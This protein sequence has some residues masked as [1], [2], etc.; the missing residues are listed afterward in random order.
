MRRQCT[1]YKKDGTRCSRVSET[2]TCRQHR[3]SNNLPKAG[4]VEPGLPELILT[5]RMRA[6]LDNFKEL[7][8]AIDALIR[9]KILNNY[10]KVDGYIV[11]RGLGGKHDP[12]RLIIQNFAIKDIIGETS[13]DIAIRTIDAIVAATKVE[14]GAGSLAEKKSEKSSEFYDSDNIDSS[15]SESSSCELIKTN[16]K[17]KIPIIEAVMEAKVRKDPA[18]NKTTIF[19]VTDMQNLLYN[20][21]VM[22]PG[23]RNENLTDHLDWK[24]LNINHRDYFTNVL[25]ND[26]IED[27]KSGGSP[28]DCLDLLNI[29][30]DITLTKIND[31]KIKTPKYCYGR[32][33]KQEANK[34][35]NMLQEILDEILDKDDDDENDD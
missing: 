10:C 21:N 2:S 26:I 35:R 27:E 1:G 3:F 16:L 31:Y 23:P 9:D 6:D 12:E 29:Q 20:F 34:I 25:L 19:T 18:T 33:A 7:P 8:L 13:T 30:W 14:T 28:D 32:H 22:R 24:K 15:D 4:L 11:E 5:F 17:A